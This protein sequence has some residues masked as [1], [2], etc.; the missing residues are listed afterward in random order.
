MAMPLIE[1]GHNVHLIANKIPAYAEFYTSFSFYQDMGQF[2]RSLKI[3]DPITD[4]FHCHNEPSYFVTALKEITKKPVILDIHDS[5]LARTTPEQADEK[6]K[7]G[8]QP[9]RILTEE[10][11]NFQLAD[12]LIFPG[13]LFAELII[14]EFKLNQPS[15]VLPSYV[16]E[17][18]YKYDCK[19]WLGG[20]VYEG[21]IDVKEEIEN[22]PHLNG[23]E[24]CDYKQL[25]E[26]LHEIHLD[27]HI[28]NPRNDEKFINI[29]KDIAFLQEPVDI[30]KLL[31][32]LTRHD[33]GLVGNIH[34]TNEWKVAFPN[35]LFEY[36]A[37]CVPVVSM[38]ANECSEFL[39]SEDV[40]ITVKS[41]NELSE[42]WKEHREKRCNLIKK[43]QQFSM[44]SHI[45]ELT[46]F[47]GNFIN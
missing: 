40:G 16:P 44:E 10:R 31:G 12:G 4:I 29:Y 39:E 19:E 32:R 21:R 15:L 23:F 36:L 13:K 30:R 27:F 11:N 47:Y 45:H 17:R 7:K 26:A 46:D 41:V 25:A 33:W 18:W 35:K 20:L 22:S 42:R 38:N 24:Y 28:Y 1:K 9:V 14:N 8:E 3:Y 2:I 34:P 43:R 6:E 37:A 5:Y